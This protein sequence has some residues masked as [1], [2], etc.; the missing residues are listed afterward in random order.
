MAAIYRT[1]FKSWERFSMDIGTVT[2]QTDTG[3][4]SI[5]NINKEYLMVQ[6]F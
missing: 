3:N 6:F 5:R 2:K 4:H 1:Y